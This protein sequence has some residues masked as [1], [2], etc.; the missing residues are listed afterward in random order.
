MI[1]EAAESGSKFI[2][3]PEYFSIPSSL[4]NQNSACRVFNETYEPTLLFLR[5]V[6]KDVNVYVVGGT[7][8]EEFRGKFYN[9]SEFS[10][11][12]S[13]LIILIIM[14]M[15]VSGI[16]ILQWATIIY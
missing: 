6:S 13:D 14:L 1:Y 2:C 3:L 9:L 8:I 5:R 15:A 11:G 10:M 4:E 7:I 12:I 16:G